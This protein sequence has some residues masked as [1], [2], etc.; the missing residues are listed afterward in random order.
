MTHPPGIGV[1]AHTANAVDDFLR[2]VFAGDVVDHHI[3]PIPGQLESDAL[4]NTRVGAGDK[5]LLALQ[6]GLLRAYG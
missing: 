1:T 4:A 5:R 3:G 2:R 6:P